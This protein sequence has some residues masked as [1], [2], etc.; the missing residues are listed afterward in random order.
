MTNVNLITIAI[1]IIYFSIVIVAIVIPKSTY[2][3]TYQG[4]NDIVRYGK[5]M[6]EFN[7]IGGPYKTNVNYYYDSNGL[8]FIKP[9]QHL[10]HDSD[11]TDD[12]VEVLSRDELGL[13]LNEMYNSLFYRNKNLVIYWNY[14]I[15]IIKNKQY[16]QYI[17]SLK[18]SLNYKLRRKQANVAKIYV[19]L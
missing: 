12:M 11:D 4:I 17:Y 2:N 18:E 3:I 10:H 1:A 8:Y 14:I 9:N 13:Q 15:I 7:V 5:Q 16:K 6:Y 19:V